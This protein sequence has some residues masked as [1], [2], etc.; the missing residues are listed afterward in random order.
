MRKKAM[1]KIW[2]DESDTENKNKVK[3]IAQKCWFS[4]RKT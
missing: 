3:G 1:E 4:S 2:R